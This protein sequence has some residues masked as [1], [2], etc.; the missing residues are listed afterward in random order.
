MI[1]F[2][3]PMIRALCEGRKTQTRREVGAFTDSGTATVD[4][5]RKDA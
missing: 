1:I 2:S 4:I 3:A 5:E